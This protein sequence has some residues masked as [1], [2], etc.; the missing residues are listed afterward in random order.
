ML[1]QQES[2]MTVR[3]ILMFIENA[4]GDRHQIQI[5]ILSEIERIN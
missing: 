2:H 3:A 1:L 4:L 5:V